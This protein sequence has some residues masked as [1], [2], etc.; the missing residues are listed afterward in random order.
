MFLLA[1]SCR[2]LASIESGDR[3]IKQIK[4]RP[5]DG[6]HK[7]TFSRGNV[8]EPEELTHEK[9]SLEEKLERRQWA[10]IGDS[11]NKRKTLATR[12]KKSRR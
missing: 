5:M 6:P 4:V 2:L 11:Y 3:M 10:K 9:S 8:D 12:A 1:S 7:K